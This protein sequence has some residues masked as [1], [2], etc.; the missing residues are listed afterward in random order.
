M[1]WK[2]CVWLMTILVS[3]SAALAADDGYP[4]SPVAD[5]KGGWIKWAVLGI[6]LVGIGAVAF[7]NPKR[8]HL[9]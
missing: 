7:K 6:C 1:I 5:P 4:G 9:D 3:F 2:W 8:T